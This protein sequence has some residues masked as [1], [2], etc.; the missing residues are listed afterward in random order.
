MRPGAD[1][2]AG[3]KPKRGSQRLPK[4]GRHKGGIVTDRTNRLNPAG[5]A[6]TGRV[7]FKRAPPLRAKEQPWLTFPRRVLHPRANAHW[8]RR[9]L[10]PR[11]KACS[12]LISF[13]WQREPSM[14]NLWTDRFLLR[15]SRE[16]LGVVDERLPS[17]RISVDSSINRRSI[18]FATCVIEIDQSPSI[19]MVF[20]SALITL[21]GIYIY[22]L[23]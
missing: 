7:S 13:G 3:T 23:S 15:R 18:V 19:G 17:S 21:L 12:N 9:T 11:W 20:R 5:W 16:N 14:A 10:F 8:N 6:I 1:N 4:R 2:D 22:D